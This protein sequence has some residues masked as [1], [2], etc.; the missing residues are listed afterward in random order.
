MKKSTHEGF[1]ARTSDSESHGHRHGRTIA[2]ALLA[3]V[4]AFAGAAHAQ[5]APPSY[6]T[7]FTG[8]IEYRNTV[9]DI[10]ARIIGLPVTLEAELG[11]E[12]AILT[13]G[14]S[15]TRVANRDVSE[16]RI[17]GALQEP[18]NGGGEPAGALTVSAGRV[19]NDRFALSGAVGYSTAE[20]NLDV[21]ENG[22]SASGS[23]LLR[24]WG[25]NAVG[26]RITGN[27]LDS[28]S[29]VTAEAVFRSDTNVGRLG[30]R[31]EALAGTISEGGSFHGQEGFENLGEQH[32]GAALELRIH[33]EERLAAAPVNSVFIEHYPGPFL[34]AEVRS[35]EGEVGLPGGLRAE[36][37]L[38][39]FRIGGGI[40]W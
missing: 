32:F 14:F 1:D 10:N 26:L 19:F 13:A 37:D 4:P 5:E 27:E 25:R 36:H 35:E 12:Y 11:E 30:L 39:A 17:E 23:G 15:A 29:S 20:T 21:S 28:D 40:R 16:W 7:D 8:G 31:F 3:S 33:D 18:I 34:R 6:T 9:A 24:L 38:T 22:L 2:R